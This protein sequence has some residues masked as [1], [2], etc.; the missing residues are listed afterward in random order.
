MTEDEWNSC[1]DWQKMLEYLRDGGK[2]SNRSLRLF[3]VGCC[4]GIWHLMTDERS[5]R[6]VEVAEMHIDGEATNVELWAASMEAEAAF[7]A[8]R[9][10]VIAR[11]VG[12]D[13]ARR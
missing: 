3:A 10:R 5:R 2:A 7:H 4:R 12:P 9:E 13:L 1:D 6:A 8:S 11:I